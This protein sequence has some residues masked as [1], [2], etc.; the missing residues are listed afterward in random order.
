MPSY[1][2]Q[3]N[4][5]LCNFCVCWVNIISVT[6]VWSL[7]FNRIL[8]SWYFLTLSSS[9]PNSIHKVRLKDILLA[10][11]WEN[12][13]GFQ[14]CEL[15]FYQKGNKWHLWLGIRNK[16]S[17]CLY[18]VGRSCVNWKKSKVFLVHYTLE[19]P[20]IFMSQTLENSEKYSEKSFPVNFLINFFRIWCQTE[21]HI[22]IIISFVSAQIPYLEKFWFLSYKRKY[23]QPMG[24][25]DS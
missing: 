24:L 17:W 23:S 3:S 1:R 9:P 14:T 6:I 20:A 7:H 5:L 12:Y 11:T 25:Q 10:N 22:I 8:R 2:N 18:R 16:Q 15:W 13:V 21:F 4:G 19:N